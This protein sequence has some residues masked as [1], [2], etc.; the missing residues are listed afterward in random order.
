MKKGVPLVEAS[1]R[2]PNGVGG[3]SGGIGWLFVFQSINN[4]P[5]VDRVAHLWADRHISLSM[6]TMSEATDDQ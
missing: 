1:V 6:T 2:S 5:S 3:G 4:A